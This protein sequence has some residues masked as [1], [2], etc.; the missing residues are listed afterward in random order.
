MTQWRCR[1]SGNAALL[2]AVVALSLIGCG[3]PNKNNI[4]LRKVLQDRDNEIAQLKRQHEGDVA[5][6][7]AMQSSATTVPS[8]DPERLHGLFTTHGIRL[9]RLTGGADLD[10]SKPGDEGLKIYLIPQDETGD[11]FKAAGSVAIE[12]F[13][14]AATETRVGRWEFTA[15]EA[16]KHWNGSALLYLYVLTCPWQT[17]PQHDK[18]TIKVTFSDALTGRSFEAQTTATVKL[19]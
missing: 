5:S 12:A 4:D 1:L 11:D 14:L 2:G 13:D 18:L 7:R 10:S 8:L 16:R 17:V 15:D 19:P 9:G 3:K 6:I